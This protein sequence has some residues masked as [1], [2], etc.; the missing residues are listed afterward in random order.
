M[1]DYLPRFNPGEAIT[2][3]AGEDITGGR[4]VSVSGDLT[5]VTSAADATHVVGVA[6][7]DTTEGDGV[8]IYRDGVQRLTLAGTVAAGDEVFA[9]D[10]GAVGAAGTVSVGVALQGGAEGDVIDVA[11]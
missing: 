5:V 3:T 1:A 7:F 6:G 8:T 2:L 4:L 9:A 10:G 11:V